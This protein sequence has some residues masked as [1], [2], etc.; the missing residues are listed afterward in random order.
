MAN[1]NGTTGA[2]TLEGT[3]DSDQINGDAGND[4]INGNGG[5]DNLSGGFGNDTVRGGDGN[6]FI[7]GNGGSDQL[8]GDSGDDNLTLIASSGG[9]VQLADGG[10]GNDTI[11]ASGTATVRGGGGNDRLTL[12]GFGAVTV[13]G[14]DGNDLFELGSPLSFA[15]TLGGGADEVVLQG[16]Y[17]PQQV[18]VISD[19]APGVDRLTIPWAQQLTAWPGGG[20]PFGTGFARLVQSGS[21]TVLE[22]DRNG[23]ANSFVGFV[24]FANT[25]VASFV[26]SDFGGFAPDGA[27]PAGQT[28]AGTTAADTLTGGVGNDVISG[29]D[30]NDNLDGNLGDDTL[31]GGAGNDNL[32]GGLGR[33][34]INGD[35]GNDS[36]LGTGDAQLF[37]GD[38]DDQLRGI[39]A[40]FAAQPTLLDGGAG[41]DFL[42]FTNGGPFGSANGSILRGGDGN[43]RI[44]IDGFGANLVDGGSGDD[45]ILLGSGLSYII[46]LGAGADVIRMRPENFRPTGPVV[47]TDYTPGTDRIEMNFDILFQGWSGATNPFAEG[48][49]RLDQVG[50]DA[51]LLRDENGSAVSTGA[52]FVEFF[53]FQNTQIAALTAA[54]FGGFAAD[55]SPPVG[56][57]VTGTAAAE[58][59]AGSVGGDLVE[60]LGGNDT[61]TGNAGDDTLNGGDGDDTLNGGIGADSLR[62]GAGNDLLQDRDGRFSDQFFGEDGNDVLRVA[63]SNVIVFGVTIRLDGGNGDDVISHTATSAD[64]ILIGGAGN[65]T[66]DANGF[67]SN[68]VDAGTGDDRVTL[69]SAIGFRVEL[70]EG[71]DVVTVGINFRPQSAADILDFN[72]A[73]DRLSIAFAPLLSNWNGT[74]PFASGHARLVQIGADTSFQLDTNGQGNSYADYVIFRGV[75]RDSLAASN[76]G[77]FDY[78][79]AALVTPWTST[80]QNDTIFGENGSDQIDGA[81][82]NDRIS[83]FA[84]NDT[85]IGGAG[86]DTLAG[87]SGSGN[88][89]FGG[90]GNDTYEVESASD[91]VFELAGEG[92]LDTVNTSV[93]FYLYANIEGLVLT[94]SAGNFGVGNDLDNILLG[95]GGANLLLGGGGADLVV[96]A[97][98][99]DIVYGEAGDDQLFGDAGNDVV[100]GGS[101]KDTIDGGT[102][103]D[104]LYGEDGNDSMIGGEDFVFDQ[105]VGGAGDDILRGDSGLGDFDYLF[106][107]AGNDSVYVDT[108]FDLVF[109]AAGEGTDTVYAN[110]VGTGYYL[111]ENIENLVLLGT[112]S[113]GVGN[114][115]DNRLTGSAAGNYLLGGAGNDTLDGGGGG[116]V[117]FGEAGADV[118]AF[119]VGGGGDV[120]GDFAVGSDRIS[121]AAFGIATFAALQARFVEVGGTTAINLGNGDFIVLNGVATAAL[122]A[123]DFIFG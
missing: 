47:I 112:T 110:I 68:I 13:D 43:D 27:V 97:G 4:V 55:G 64:S 90:T 58:V 18:T 81:A 88:L 41:N 62:G 103:G 25:Q 38:D 34:V 84:G 114:G 24:R 15:L 6:D 94:G 60:G 23:G 9:D 123:G 79:A 28:L 63:T 26:A 116:D 119:F 39:G 107:D 69:G 17:A 106:G 80:A 20:N 16:N 86:D 78:T 8:F 109:E 122:T 70:G 1:I 51:V 52:G 93:S 72:P 59:L 75:Q 36:L 35:A 31:N 49:F 30:G 95:N 120:I 3:A 76:F 85:L 14:G 99:I 73:V 113:F 104:L 87:G 65:D 57:T 82:G 7:A 46:T 98:G 101:G 117:L 89:L 121:L 37:G 83:G 74:N 54:T 42:N 29:G 45:D 115:L 21:D 44:E 67:G 5:A 11:Y 32:T 48:F 77:G 12:Q 66:I 100:V 19:F 2:D 91:L 105:L 118:F 71:A 96:A 56:T 50:A 92:F 40:R 22:L 53:R 33:D 10:E 111:Y 102:G 61:L 108:P